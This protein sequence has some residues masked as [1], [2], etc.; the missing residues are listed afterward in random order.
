[1]VGNKCDKHSLRMVS[2]SEG[3]TLASEISVPFFETSAKGDVNV[4]E[5][6]LKMAR[7]AKEGIDRRTKEVRHCLGV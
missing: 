4:E 5:A 2:T 1:M 3:S 7:D 6:F